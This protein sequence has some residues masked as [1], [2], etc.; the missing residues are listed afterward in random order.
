[1]VYRC[2]EP[3]FLILTTY[4]IF[5]VS[6]I[7]AGIYRGNW[8]QRSFLKDQIVVFL[9]SPGSQQSPRGQVIIGSELYHKFENT[10]KQIRLL[11]R[12]E[13]WKK[14]IETCQNSIHRAVGWFYL[15]REIGRCLLLCTSCYFPL[16]VSMFHDSS[17]IT[18]NRKKTS[19]RHLLIRCVH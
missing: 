13:T 14:K 5:Q 7:N 3:P 17:K 11:S 16:F 18:L 12:W 8:M 15:T 2:T 10:W 6:A 9:E 1:M 19:Q 4:T